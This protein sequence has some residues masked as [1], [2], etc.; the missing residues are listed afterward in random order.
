MA[1]PNVRTAY[2][3]YSHL[4]SET[5]CSEQCPPLLVTPVTPGQRSQEVTAPDLCLQRARL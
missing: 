2:K 1:E 5:E 4:C 3:T